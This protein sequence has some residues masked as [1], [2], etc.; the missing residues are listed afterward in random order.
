MENSDSP[1]DILIVGKA[2]KEKIEKIVKKYEKELNRDI[3]YTS[4]SRTEFK[5]RMDITD[6]FLYEIM[7]GEKVVILD[8]INAK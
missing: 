2:K 3:N 4:M 1:V 7:E 6:R 8:K 5:Y